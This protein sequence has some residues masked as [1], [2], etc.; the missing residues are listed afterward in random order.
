MGP[1][2]D[3]RTQARSP[4]AHKWPKKAG[5]RAHGTAAGQV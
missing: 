2:Q 4:A 1:H 5:M 3:L